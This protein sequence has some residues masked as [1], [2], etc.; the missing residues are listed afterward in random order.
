MLK[1]ITM[2]AHHDNSM[3]N[4][5]SMIFFVFAGLFNAMQSITIES[6]YIWVFRILSLIS[7]LMIMIIN[8]PKVKAVLFK[9]KKHD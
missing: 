1:K 8:Y 3:S 7:L 6:T 5:T 9:K 4:F 2:E